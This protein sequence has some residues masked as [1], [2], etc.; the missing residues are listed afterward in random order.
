MDTK[1]CY[2]I[3]KP[4]VRP[5]PW[6]KVNDFLGSAHYLMSWTFG[7]MYL[8]IPSGDGVLQ[9]GHKFVMDGWMHS[10]RGGKNNVSTQYRVRRNDK[11]KIST[12]SF[13][14][15]YRQSNKLQ[16]WKQ[17][18]KK[19]LTNRIETCQPV[20]DNYS[21]GGWLLMDWTVYYRLQCPCIFYLLHSESS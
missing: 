4:M 21:T 17:N 5:W 11:I 20:W 9:C 8:K 6:T 14:S 2:M 7:P 10:H 16:S 19:I 15:L 18:D 13:F 12:L 3:F 1:C